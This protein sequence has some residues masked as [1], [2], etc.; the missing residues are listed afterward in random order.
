MHNPI[1]QPRLRKMK[2]RTVEGRVSYLEEIITAAHNDLVA[3]E[4]DM[5]RA[6]FYTVIQSGLKIIHDQQT[7]QSIEDLDQRL[8]ELEDEYQKLNAKK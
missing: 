5:N 8:Q 2:L 6:R 7:D 4:T 1:I 3:A